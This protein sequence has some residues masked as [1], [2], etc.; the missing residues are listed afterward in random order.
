MI[1]T[2]ARLPESGVGQIATSRRIPYLGDELFAPGDRL[3]R[4]GGCRFAPVPYPLDSVARRFAS[5]KRLFV[6]GDRLFE[7]G[8][9]RNATFHRRGQAGDPPVAN[10][11]PQPDQTMSNAVPDSHA[12]R[13]AFFINLKA[14]I[15]ADAA[16]LGWNAAKLAAVNALLDPVIAN[17]QTLVDAEDAAAQASAKAAQAFAERNEN[18][19]KLI[20]ELRANPG[21]D[22]GMREGMQL[23]KGTGKRDPNKIK[24]RL[25]AKADPGHVR[26]SGSKDY[27]DLI[28][29]YMRLVGTTA[30]ILVGVRRMKFP[31]DDQTPLKVA[32][33]PETREYMGRG[34]IG[35]DE[36]GE[37]S[38]IVQVTFGG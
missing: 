17:Y 34:V 21:L 18:L 7:A 24:P 5:G 10:P 1:A 16:A 38:D 32:G 37:E 25:K 2:G 20:E 19:N 35:D 29:I 3:L 8:D 30:W 23:P 33:T 12:N 9:R 4:S 6:S 36:V 11:T 13:L 27:A 28:N 15:A 22:D 31:F 26:I 14:K